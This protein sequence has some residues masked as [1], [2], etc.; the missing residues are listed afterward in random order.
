MMQDMV[1]ITAK[2]KTFEQIMVMGGHQD[3]QR[4]QFLLHFE[5]FGVGFP[6]LEEDFVLTLHLTGMNR[7]FKTLF[8]K[9]F[10]LFAPTVIGV[11]HM[12]EKDPAPQ[13]GR[14][15]ISLMDHLFADF[16]VIQ[17]NQ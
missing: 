15:G 12:K 17:R 9:R 2:E 7:F 4:F 1:G 13:V 8:K 6:N 16:G 3:H 10:F 5:D 11:D 14:P